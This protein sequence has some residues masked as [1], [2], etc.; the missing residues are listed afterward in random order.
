MLLLVCWARADGCAALPLPSS[1]ALPP[2]SSNQREESVV[3]QAAI[4]LLRRLPGVTDANYRGLLSGVNSLAE[5]ADAS[6]PRLQEMMGG[7][8]AAQALHTFLH[9][10]C[11]LSGL[12]AGG[13]SVALEA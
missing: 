9:A 6:L 8:K 1:S 3:N 7:A 2:D 10:E 13:S 5:L 12:G 11:P 4:D